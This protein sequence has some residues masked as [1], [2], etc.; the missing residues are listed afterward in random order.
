M[1]IVEDFIRKHVTFT[2]PLI[3]TSLRCSFIA[4]FISHSHSIHLLH[5]YINIVLLYI[6]FDIK[7][8]DL[9]FF[10]PFYYRNAT[11]IHAQM[12]AHAG[13][14]MNHFI[15]HVM[16]VSPHGHNIVFSALIYNNKY[17]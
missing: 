6:F 14:V 4:I 9:C 13:P 8:L 17:N 3:G 1:L 5:S 16:Q 11:S 2:D 15:V 7:F 12:V 10:I